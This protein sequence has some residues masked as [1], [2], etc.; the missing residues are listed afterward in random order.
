[1]A[2]SANPRLNVEYRCGA[3]LPFATMNDDSNT[4]S[5]KLSRLPSLLPRVEDRR[6]IY[7]YSVLVNMYDVT[8]NLAIDL[9]A[10]KLQALGNKHA[11]KM[12]INPD[13]EMP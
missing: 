2:S 6:K 11:S 5:I 8:A 4:S 3:D 10:A 13:S 9:E 1:M 12:L 7:S